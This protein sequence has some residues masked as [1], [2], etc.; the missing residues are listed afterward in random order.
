MHPLRDRGPGVGHQ[1]ADRVVRDHPPA[2]ERSN[3]RGARGQNQR[4]ILAHGARGQA[5]VGGIIARGR[6]RA[7]HP[8]RDVV[9]FVGIDFRRIQYFSSRTIRQKNPAGPTNT[10]NQFK[11]YSGI[12]I[13]VLLARHGN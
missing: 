11:G 13:D 7:V 6:D 4:S 1:G 12:I 9:V 2:E 8:G 5:K 3:V 10:P